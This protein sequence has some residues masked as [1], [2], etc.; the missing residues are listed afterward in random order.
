MV[1][2][3]TIWISVLVAIGFS[4]LVRQELIGRTKVGGLSKAALFLT[5]I[6][7]N[8]KKVH[9][10]SESFGELYDLFLNLD[11]FDGQPSED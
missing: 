3:L 11:G 4:I 9:L 10:I 6:P 7:M 5:E 1:L 2:Y 8:L